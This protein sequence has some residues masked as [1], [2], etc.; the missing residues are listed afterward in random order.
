MYS[1]HDDSDA[2]EGSDLEPDSDAGVH[3]LSFTPFYC[4]RSLGTSTWQ[5]RSVMRSSMCI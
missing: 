1:L 2:D 5:Q 4:C 3:I